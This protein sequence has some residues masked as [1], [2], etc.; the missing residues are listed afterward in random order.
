MLFGNFSKLQKKT[1]K[2]DPNYEPKNG[3]RSLADTGRHHFGTSLFMLQDLTSKL[4]CFMALYR[5]KNVHL[6]LYRNI[7]NPINVVEDHDKAKCPKV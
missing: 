7:P 4:S 6:F 5:L 2:P 1:E 3:L